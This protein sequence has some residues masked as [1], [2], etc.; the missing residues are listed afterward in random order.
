MNVHDLIAYQNIGLPDDILRRKLHGDFAGAIR[1]IEKRLA[2][3]KTS[4]ALANS[5]RFH[6][7]MILR[8]PEDFPYSKEEA[9]AIMQEKIPDFTPKTP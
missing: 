1:L 7:E 8:L 4:L 9:L 3:P 2:D 6:K 5:L